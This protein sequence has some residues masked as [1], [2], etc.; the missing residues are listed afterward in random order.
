MKK[1]ISDKAR[2]QHML[3]AI[4]QIQEFT[5]ELMLDEYM[6]DLK[7]RLAVARLVEIIG[8]AANTFLN[9]QQISLLR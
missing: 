4:C 3:S 1:R 5:K 9:R 8:E 6:Q 7:L 2:I